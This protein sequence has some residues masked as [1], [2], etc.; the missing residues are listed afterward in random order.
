MLYTTAIG[1]VRL[2]FVSEQD[3]L[4]L[5]LNIFPA[6]FTNLGKLDECIADCDSAL[7][8]NPTYLKAL[9]RRAQA[10]DKKGDFYDAL[11]DYTAMCIIEEFKVDATV[12]ATDKVLKEVAKQK[13]EEIMKS[14]AGKQLPSPVFISAYLDSFRTCEFEG[15]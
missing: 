13:S 4:G 10:L 5:K 15:L 2:V 1:Q 3:P 9:G 8:I 6:C 11:V 12:Q 14:K 7:K